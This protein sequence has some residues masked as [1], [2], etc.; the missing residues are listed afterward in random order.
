MKIKQ[1]K[2]AFI[3]YTDPAAYPPVINASTI[4]AEQ[5]WSVSF[6]GVRGE[7]DSTQMCMPLHAA[8]S[9][10]LLP[11]VPPGWR[12]KLHYFTFAIHC[13]FR[14]LLWR[15]DVVYVSDS[16]AYPIEWFISWIPGVRTIAHE[17][18]TPPESGGMV[19]RVFRFFRRQLFR[20]SLLT[21][22]PQ[23]E[24]ARKV[25]EST[26]AKD[27]RVVFNCPRISEIK[28]IQQARRLGTVTLWYHGSIVPSQF[29]ISVIHALKLLPSHVQLRF[30]GYETI[31]SKGYVQTLPV[32]AKKCGVD[33][34]VNYAGTMP[35]RQQLFDEA[36]QC[37]IGLA[38]FAR[39]FREPMVGASNK[40]FDYLACGLAILVNDTEEWRGF[41]SLCQSA[42]YCNPESAR[43]IAESINDLIR[44]EQRF[45]R[46]R[47]QGQSLIQ[48]LWNYDNQFAQ[49]ATVVNKD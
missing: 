23:E 7:G 12:Q 18:D 24:R 31:G 36:A 19:I 47:L 46:E 3:Q 28:P 2:I 22:I 35:T 42:R 10:H 43:D 8:M 17:H 44:D 29:P 41:F 40:P 5:G 13:V 33:A 48:Q 14:A 45:H 20:R 30:A 38:L 9:L 15:P 4:L 34:R 1:R 11:Y 25:K 21:V 49:I 16:W 6:W 27:V 26:L 37:D 39:Q 32:E